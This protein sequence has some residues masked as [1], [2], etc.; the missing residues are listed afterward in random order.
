MNYFWVEEATEIP[1][2]NKSL[3]FF[4]FGAKLNPVSKARRKKSKYVPNSPILNFFQTEIPFSPIYRMLHRKMLKTLSVFVLVR[5]SFTSNQPALEH[6]SVL[7]V[8]AGALGHGH[9]GE[10]KHE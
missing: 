7:V 1:K 9:G 6:I 8:V 2:K 4:L 3:G 10:C 5:R